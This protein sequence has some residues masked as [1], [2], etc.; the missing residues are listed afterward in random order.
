MGKVVCKFWCPSGSLSLRPPSPSPATCKDNMA[1]EI[2]L[3]NYN[4]CHLL[5]DQEIGRV[6]ILVMSTGSILITWT[7]KVPFIL[8]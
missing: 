5:L 8:R 1:Q 3:L 4:K 7:N 6:S 2:E